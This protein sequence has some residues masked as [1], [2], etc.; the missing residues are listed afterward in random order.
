MNESFVPFQLKTRKLERCSVHSSAAGQFLITAQDKVEFSSIDTPYA[1]ASKGIGFIEKDDIF[2]L[3]HDYTA[4]LRTKVNK[5]LGYFII[6]PTLRC[7]LLCSYCQVSRASETASGYDWDDETV[8]RF[9]EFFIE[10]SSEAPKLE[11]QGGEPL[12]IFPKLKKM[13]EEIHKIKPKTE[14]VICTNLQVIPEN[15]WKFAKKHNIF[16]S[17]SIDGPSKLHNKNRNKDE[18]GTKQ[19]FQNLTDAIKHLGIDYVSALPTITD[20]EDLPEVTT[21]YRKLGFKEIFMRP[22][23]YQG[24]ARKSFDQ[25]S[26]NQENWNKAYL[27]SLAQ[28]FADNEVNKNKIIEI[29][30]ALHIKKIFAPSFKSHVDFRNPNPVAEDYL[31]INF[32]G[33]F[34]PSDEAR[35]LHRV[36]YVD[37]SIGSLTD[38][39]DYKAIAT[40]NDASTLDRYKACDECAFKPFC[41]IDITDLISRHGTLDVAMEDTYHCK[42]HIGVFDYIFTKLF[43]RDPVFLRNVNLCLTGTYD[44]TSVASGLIYD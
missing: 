11:I 3:A 38:G 34:F 30:F 19:F 43:E 26:K 40:L 12:L 35:M 33:T 21:F 18:I 6:V 42:N 5:G 39:F 7:N 9:L 28:I 20:F 16:I 8:K 36:G 2:S 23:N 15:F 14:V 4:F 37:L 44:M 1:L 25:Q 24:F 22:V 17:T 29:N 41:G 13:I 10:H 27:S 32:D 31:V